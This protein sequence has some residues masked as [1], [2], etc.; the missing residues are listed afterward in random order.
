M[1]CAPGIVERPAVDGSNSVG[2]TESAL[3]PNELAVSIVS[4]TLGLSMITSAPSFCFCSNTLEEG[5]SSFKV[6]IEDSLTL[7]DS[8]FSFSE[9]APP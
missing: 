9:A 2:V 3:D 5:S 6:S 1:L 7:S 8:C 4:S